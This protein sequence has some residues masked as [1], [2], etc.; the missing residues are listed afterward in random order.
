MT[1]HEFSMLA[2]AVMVPLLGV[3]V[4]KLLRLDDEDDS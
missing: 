4:V 3:V 1:L 2:I